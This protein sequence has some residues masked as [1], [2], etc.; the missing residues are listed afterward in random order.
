MYR[1][2]E[3]I[4]SIIEVDALTKLKDWGLV[5]RTVHKEWNT[6]LKQPITIERNPKF[7]WKYFMKCLSSKKE[8]IKK[9]RMTASYDK[10]IRCLSKL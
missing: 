10:Q 3:S 9:D 8:I 1:T 6:D 4:Q 2:G 5:Q 7:L